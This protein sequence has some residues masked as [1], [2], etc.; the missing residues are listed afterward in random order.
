[1]SKRLAAVVLAAGF[2]RRYGEVSKLHAMLAGR[3]VLA[4]ALAPLATL[5]LQTCWVVSA[6]ED[7][8]AVAL[9][10]AAGANC[11]AHAGRADGLGSSLARGIRALVGEL[12][13][14]LVV[15]GDMPRI[16][17]A[18]YRTLIDAFE[19]LDNTAIVQPS[20][21]GRG[22]H[23]VLFGAEYLAEL[24]TLE[25]DQGARAVLL[26][27]AAR[28]VKLDSGEPG[29]LLDIDTPADLARALEPAPEAT[30]VNR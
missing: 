11:V 22:G 12:D 23:P 15:L 20:W 16:T 14:V 7:L 6:P 25:G 27:H 9:A 28:V 8:A 24:A 26:K 1:M 21:A 29:V 10:T 2:S 4:C 5:S 3:P 13:G 18:V 17:P 19:D 30:Q